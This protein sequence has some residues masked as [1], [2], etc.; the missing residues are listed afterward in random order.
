MPA[1]NRPA[2]RRARPDR[3]VDRSVGSILLAILLAM[4]VVAAMPGCGG[5]GA[6]SRPGG[7][8]VLVLSCPV[9]E[10]VLWV[11]GHYVAQLRDL[12]GGVAL[13]PGHH[14]IELRHDTYHA[15]YGDIHLGTGQRLRLEVELAEILP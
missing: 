4:I 9:A 3:E 15:Y 14:Q 5:G 1:P 12:R 10:A 8:A 13:P 7:R 2:P 11:D 6:G